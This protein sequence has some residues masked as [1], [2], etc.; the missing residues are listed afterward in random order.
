MSLGPFGHPC[1][2]IAL[3]SCGTKNVYIYKGDC[4]YVNGFTSLA[5]RFSEVVLGFVAIFL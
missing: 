3:M 2:Q 4:A 1:E 5:E